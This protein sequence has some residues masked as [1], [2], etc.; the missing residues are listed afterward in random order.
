MAGTI[1]DLERSQHSWWQSQTTT[2][3]P[4]DQALTWERLESFQRQYNT[5]VSQ[6]TEQQWRAN[7]IYFSADQQWHTWDGSGE[8]NTL[9]GGVHCDGRTYTKKQWAQLKV[10]EG[11]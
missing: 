6:Q 8:W 2:T 9:D 4:S 7:R 3:N 5:I 10:A 11:L 1:A